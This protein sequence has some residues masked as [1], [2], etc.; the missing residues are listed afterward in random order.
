MAVTG[1]IKLIG[2]KEL[3]RKLKAL[4]RKVAKKILR[5]ALRAGAKIILAQAKANAPVA[6]GQ[7]KK[8]LK[9]RAMKRTRK[10][11]VGFKVQTK[12]GDFKGDEFYGSFLEY[13]FRRGKRPGKGAEYTREIVPAQPFMRPA[14]DSKKDEAVA[15][16]SKELSAKI[17]T[18][19]KSG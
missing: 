14:F 1:S 7:L 5:Q 12:A 13:G 9:V 10:G 19:A 3:D 15:V 8:S 16:I 2:G 17:V 11:T 4:P 18:A 6:T